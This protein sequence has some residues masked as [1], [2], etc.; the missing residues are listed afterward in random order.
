MDREAPTGNTPVLVT[1]RLTLRPLSEAD[2]ED[3]R[4]ISNEPDVRRYLWDDEPV[5]GATIRDLVARSRSMF[6]EEN[7]GLFGVRVGG[8]EDLLGFCGFVRLGGMDEPELGY[9]LTRGA[10]GRGFATEAA[11]VCLRY[12]FDRAGLER[13][14][15]GADA[16]NAASMRVIEKLGMRSVGN[17]NAGAPDEPYFALYR[18]DFLARAQGTH[19][20]R[21]AGGRGAG[22]RREHPRGR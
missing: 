4:R 1:E 7:I 14:I 12:A 2:A 10:W 22:G 13:V 5:S 20:G 15:A 21:S 11:E 19:P 9:M 16:P 3:L 8:G 18:K 6:S 17:I